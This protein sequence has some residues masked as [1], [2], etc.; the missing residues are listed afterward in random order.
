MADRD[1]TLKDIFSS[2]PAPYT[3]PRGRNAGIDRD[4]TLVD[5]GMKNP[6]RKGTINPA[7]A[8]MLQGATLGFGD[9]LIAKL[10]AASTGR[11]YEELIASER[12]QLE[13][14]NTEHPTSHYA[15]ELMGGLTTGGPLTSG[16]RHGARALVPKATKYLSETGFKPALARWG[17]SGGYGGALGGGYGAGTAT[18]GKRLEGAKEGAVT[19][20][21]VTGALTPVLSGTAALIKTTGK[22]L[23]PAGQA[24][25]SALGLTN[26]PKFS[27]KVF[28]NALEKDSDT[29]ETVLRRL[30]ELSQNKDAMLM[31]VL[32]PNATGVIK[33]A[34]NTTGPGKELA[35][36]ILEARAADQ[37]ARLAEDVR[38]LIS[39]KTSY[40][41]ELDDLIKTRTEKS[42]PLYDQAFNIGTLKDPSVSDYFANSP[43]R[44]H[45]YGMTKSTATSNKKEPFQMSMDVAPDGSLV[46]KEYPSVRDLDRIKR[47]IDK[48][49]DSLWDPKERRFSGTVS[50]AG[51]EFNAQELLEH[52]NELT[53]LIENLTG[54]A[55]SPYTA[56]RKV[57]GDASDV[58]SALS[59]GYNSVKAHP[60]QVAKEH[61]LLTSEAEQEAYLSGV[62]SALHDLTGKDFSNHALLKKIYGSDVRRKLDSILPAE[63]SG[64][65]EKRM[66]T[67][68]IMAKQGK[69][70]LPSVTSEDFAGGGVGDVNLLSGAAKA[71]L[72]QYGGAISNA[73]R[74]VGVEA[75]K[76]S[77]AFAEHLMEI[78][79][80]N[81]VA[82]EEF[83]LSIG[84]KPPSAL[85]KV[86][87]GVVNDQV[88]SGKE[89]ISP[90][91]SALVAQTPEKVE[92]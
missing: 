88:A 54:G 87:T 11:P 47:H 31:D 36:N 80:K 67:E 82:A 49:I 25:M 84:Y 27:Q 68:A 42:K 59:K 45:W 43:V 51:G 69:N 55:N 32:G 22:V 7:A 75:G 50:E 5:M 14:F 72:G 53:K 83:L 58:K 46:W 18:E 29:P 21:A 71:L 63:V 24:L 90:L 81:P 38:E 52:K 85:K 17:T 41:N 57:F 56:A 74:L 35:R 15:T 76:Y 28:L 16:I 40:V 86:V 73:Q 19:G 12:A 8:S 62:A 30:K 1:V 20:A 79:L 2:P 10:K 66:L 44:Q 78:A 64:E 9:E 89:L 91:I 6:E 4:L 34:A 61:S 60:D 77:P 33:A 48:K 70:V 92:E 37:P 3:Q 23:A 39:S 13:E 65:L 26:A